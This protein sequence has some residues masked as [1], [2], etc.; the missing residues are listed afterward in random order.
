MATAV[1]KDVAKYIQ[2]SSRVDGDSPVVTANS[3]PA[4]FAYYEHQ[5]KMA[6]LEVAEKPS[7]ANGLSHSQSHYYPIRQATA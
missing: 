1:A 6:D 2:C 7:A 5:N 3:D 4:L